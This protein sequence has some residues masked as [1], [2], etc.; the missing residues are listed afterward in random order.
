MP[1]FEIASNATAFEEEASRIH[2]GLRE[3][4]AS[5]VRGASFQA[6]RVVV[7]SEANELIGG[8]VGGTYWGWLHVE[9]LWVRDADRQRGYGTRLL[10]MAESEARRRGCRAAFLDT[11]SFQARP[12]YER[13]GYRVVGT[14]PDFPA[15]HE[16]YF[17]VK[18]LS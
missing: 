12:L 3:F 18:R 9:T 8:L 11:F 5:A 2:A 1:R 6:I 4:N 13:R 7:R 16:R 10:A 14:I 17:M 15:G